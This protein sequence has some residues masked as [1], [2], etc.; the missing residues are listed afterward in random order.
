MSKTALNLHIDMMKSEL[1]EMESTNVKFGLLLK[2]I[3]EAHRLLKLEQLDI[4]DAYHAG[5]M[6]QYTD[7]KQSSL[8]YYD[9]KYKTETEVS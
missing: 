9:E 4:M 3:R 5:R 7:N 1:K 2:L 6:Q 8:E